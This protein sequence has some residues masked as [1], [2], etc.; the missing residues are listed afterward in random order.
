MLEAEVVRQLKSL[1]TSTLFEAQG[2]KGALPGGIRPIWR[3]AF[4][5]GPAYTVRMEPGDNL[6]LHHAVV[7]A[8]R[9]DVLVADCAGFADSGVWGEV[10]TVA[11]MNRGIAGLIV[12][13]SVR[14]IARLEALGFPVFARGV[15]MGGTSKGDSG[16]QALKLSLGNVVVSPGDIIVADSDGVLAIEAQLFE[17]V[18]QSAHKREEQEK[19]M[20][21]ALRNGGSTIDLMGLTPPNS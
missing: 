21:Q 12:N 13:G 10:L 17:E 8:A 1:G 3:G 5:A 7:R 19:K 11:A 16:A 4:A 9:G 6:A 2:K 14:D 20:M 18:L 15:S